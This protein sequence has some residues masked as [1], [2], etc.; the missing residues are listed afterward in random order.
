MN[1]GVV[2][3]LNRVWIGSPNYSGRGGANV[4]LVVLH[5]AQGALT[6]QA[7]GSYFANPSSGVSS[8]V[9]IDD[10]PNTVGE[11][12]HPNYKAW[13]QANAN[14]VAL[15]AE[16]CAFAE[17]TTAQWHLHPNM[18]E[19]AALWVRETCLTYGIPIVRLSPSQA[20]GNGVGVCHHVDLGSWGG[21]HWDCGPNFPMDEV[22]QLAKGS[23]SPSPHPSKGGNMIASTSTGEGYWTVTTD[24]AIGAFGDAQFKGGANGPPSVIAPGQQIVGIAGKG[25]DG[26]WLKSSDGSVYAYGS[27]PYKGRPD[28][29]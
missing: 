10:T 9:G 22:I 11:Y 29:G 28:R 27:A 12:V 6:Y 23:P 8:H 3:S 20:Q 19:N 18:L 1:R 7:L 24:G 16:L 14:P 13:T 21:S 15:A 4:R 25:T 26:Y 17:W 5:T 2:M